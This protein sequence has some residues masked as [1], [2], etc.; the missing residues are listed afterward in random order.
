MVV[1]APA[2]A[3]PYASGIRNTTGNTWE[4][5]LNQ[6]ASGVSVVRNGGNA[7]NLGAL[8]AGRYTFDMTGFS[9]FD[10]KVANNAPTAWSWVNNTASLYDDFERPTGMAVNSNP[11]NLAYFG[12]VYVNNSTTL[13]SGTGRTMGD[14]VYAL[15]GRFERDQ[16]ERL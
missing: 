2:L 1:T 13:T 11:A 8:A 9:T 10:I 15:V 6:G 16:R 14:G 4:F 5:V 3:V 12:T 7:L